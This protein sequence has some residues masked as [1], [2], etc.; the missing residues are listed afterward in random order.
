MVI[1]LKFFPCSSSTLFVF[2]F[3]CSTTIALLQHW[4]DYSTAKLKSIST[5]AISTGCCKTNGR[6]G[7][8]VC[9]QLKDVRCTPCLK[10]VRCSWLYRQVT[11]LGYVILFWT[12]PNNYCSYSVQYEQLPGIT[13]EY[14]RPYSSRDNS[15]NGL[16]TENRLWSQRTPKPYEIKV[17]NCKL[18][19][20]VIRIELTR[21][22]LKLR[23]SNFL[24][25]FLVFLYLEHISWE[26]RFRRY[27]GSSLIIDTC[28]NLSL[29]N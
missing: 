15:I 19:D 9:H 18:I 7:H 2:C 4:N 16:S 28:S 25:N 23:F 17:N 5:N 8:S 12:F 24:R 27:T 1:Q 6:T 20:L 3:E 21:T 29:S 22:I 26:S 13:A 10:G 14:A 11:M